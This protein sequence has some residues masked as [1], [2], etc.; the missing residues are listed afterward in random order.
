MEQCRDPVEWVSVAIFEPVLEDVPNDLV[1][2]ERLYVEDKLRVNRCEATEV[3][4]SGFVGGSK[5]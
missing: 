4:R 1:K 3:N 2:G 5:S